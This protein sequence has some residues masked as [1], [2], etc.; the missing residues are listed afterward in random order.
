MR[1][2]SKYFFNIQNHY[3][4]QSGYS[5]NTLM[6][7]SNRYHP[8]TKEIISLNDLAV[9][10]YDNKEFQKAHKACMKIYELEP[11]P[12]ILRQ[13]IDL[14]TQHMRYHMILGET[15]YRN[16]NL[17]EAI[18]V[19]NRL[20]SLGKHV[21]NKYTLLAKVHLENG[22]YTKALQEYKEMIAECHQRFKSILSGL[23]DIINLNPFIERPYKLLHNL[24]KKGL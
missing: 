12:D 8:N 5:R 7:K 23:L 15:Y 19:L 20:K 2:Y 11:S 10:Y 24:Y 9:A 18:K 14:G 3:Y 13:S 1:G 6:S 4:L 16:G 22:D 17:P 21:S